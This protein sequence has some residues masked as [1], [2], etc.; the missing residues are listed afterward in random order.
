MNAAANLIWLATLVQFSCQ[1][2][3]TILWGL[4]GGSAILQI[5]IPACI[6]AATCCLMISF[7]PCPCGRNDKAANCCCSSS[8][9][10]HSVSQIAMN[11]VVI[12]CNAYIH[13]VFAI[14]AFHRWFTLNFVVLLLA[15]ALIIAYI[16]QLAGVIGGKG[17]SA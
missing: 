8:G 10:C 15:V 2:A 13:S 3:Y 14:I 4:D 11:V 9:K 12:G 6:S 7:V 1:A 17:M 16:L 5:F